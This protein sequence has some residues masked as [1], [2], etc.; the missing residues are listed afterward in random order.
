M[1]FITEKIGKKDAG[2]KKQPYPKKWLVISSFELEGGLQLTGG[3]RSDWMRG[4]P[5]W[6]RCFFLILNLETLMVLISG[7]RS[8]IM[9]WL[10]LFSCLSHLLMAIVFESGT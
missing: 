5:F 4:D 6:R 9:S 7:C 10:N 2:G 8:V 3:R 1:D